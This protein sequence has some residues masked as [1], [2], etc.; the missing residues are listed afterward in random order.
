MEW[1][2]YVFNLIFYM[3][4]IFQCAF[5]LPVH[6]KLNFQVL[7]LITATIHFII[8]CKKFF[9]YFILSI[10]KI[11]RTLLE[12]FKP[13]KEILTAGM[14]EIHDKT[15]ETMQIF[16]V[17]LFENVILI[18]FSNMLLIFLHLLNFQVQPYS[19][20][21]HIAVCPKHF[22]IFCI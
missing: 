8:I 7:V 5:N 21:L 3:L 22:M 10:S 9:Q 12:I 20:Q 13:T 14:L 17:F 16:V 4:L 19:V 18:L 11:A 15:Y 1:T 6:I 2:I